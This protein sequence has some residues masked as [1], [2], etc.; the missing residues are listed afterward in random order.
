ME[1]EDGVRDN[2][3]RKKNE[4]GKVNGKKKIRG[5]GDSDHSQIPG[6]SKKRY[7]RCSENDCENRCIKSVTTSDNAPICNIHKLKMIEMGK[8]ECIKSS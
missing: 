5:I 2:H 7:Y 6:K 1:S 8:N 4:N 3:E